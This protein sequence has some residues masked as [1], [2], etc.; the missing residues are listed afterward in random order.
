MKYPTN[1]PYCDCIL[2]KNEY[3]NGNISFI[4]SNDNHSHACYFFLSNKARGIN[5]VFNLIS[6]I[7]RIKI[8]EDKTSVHITNLV[9]HVYYKLNFSLPIP[10]NKEEIKQLID[11]IMKNSI[12]M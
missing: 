8:T 11:R 1:C 2:D 9:P 12:F 6:F 10:T 5:G 3:A 4:C 7:Y